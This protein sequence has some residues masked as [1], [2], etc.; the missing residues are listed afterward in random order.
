[1]MPRIGL[2]ARVASEAAVPGYFRV[3]VTFVPSRQLVSKGWTLDAYLRI[4][5]LLITRQF[6]DFELQLVII[7][8]TGSRSM[9]R[10]SSSQR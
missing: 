8:K 9:S 10:L 3:G 6:E 1:M 5:L 7:L 2:C 4:D